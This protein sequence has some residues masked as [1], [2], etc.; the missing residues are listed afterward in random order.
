MATEDRRI[1]IEPGQL[2]LDRIRKD[3]EFMKRISEQLT[4]YRE[5]VRE[6]ITKRGKQSVPSLRLYSYKTP[7]ENGAYTTVSLNE[8]E[9]RGFFRLSRHRRKRIQG[10]DPIQV[11]EHYTHNYYPYVEAVG[12]VDTPSRIVVISGQIESIGIPQ[13]DTFLGELRNDFLKKVEI[14]PEGLYVMRERG[15]LDLNSELRNLI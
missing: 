2:Y 4:T 7:T 15:I 9:N 12:I 6:I 3:S 13:A 8:S 14:T 10:I 11:D 1:G 5:L